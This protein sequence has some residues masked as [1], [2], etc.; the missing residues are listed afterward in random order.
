MSNKHYEDYRQSSFSLKWQS[1]SLVLSF[2][3]FCT[4]QMAKPTFYPHDA[5]LARILAV[6]VCLCVCVY[7]CLSVTRRYCI[8]T[9][10]RRITQTTPRDSP[11]TLVF[12]RQK[13][14]VDDSPSPWNLRS[15][16]P[17]PFRNHDFDK[18]PLIAP[19][20]WLRGLAK[21]VQLALI[22]RRPCAFQ[23]AI[24]EPFTL[25]LC[26]PNCCTKRDFAVFASK[27]QLL[28]TKVCHKVFLCEHFQQQRCS[29]II[30]LS[31]S[32]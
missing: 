21:K 23:R 1:V 19:Q 17:T 32:P 20:L 24:N 10:K 4:V 27:I 31:N 11:G 5:M 25:P 29:Y 16:W 18:Y 13:S 30:P 3:I 15:K 9:A 26:P 6:V 7:V 14:L 2:Q 22:G 12:W 28:S 8:K